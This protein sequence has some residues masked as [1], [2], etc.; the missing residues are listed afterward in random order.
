MPQ[1]NSSLRMEPYYVHFLMFVDS[2]QQVS[3]VVGLQ[4]AG[5]DEYC[6]SISA[7]TIASEVGIPDMTIKIL[8]CKAWYVHQQQNRP[9]PDELVQTA[10]KLTGLLLRSTDPTGVLI[11]ISAVCTCLSSVFI[12]VSHPPSYCPPFCALPVSAPLLSYC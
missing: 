12:H 4:G 8:D 9:T 11:V 2:I 3:L 10:V 6:F 1:V 7:A 5:L